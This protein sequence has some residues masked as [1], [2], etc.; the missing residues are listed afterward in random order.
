MKIDHPDQYSLFEEDYLIRELPKGIT[1]KPDVALTELVANA[2]DAGATRVDIHLPE[3]TDGNL[4]VEDDGTGMSYDQFHSRWMKLRYNRIKHQGDQVEFPPELTGLQRAAYGRNGIGRHG[5]LCFN[6]YYEVETGNG[7]EGW[8]YRIV[9]NHPELPF[10]VEQEEKLSSQRRGTKL[11]VRV[12]RHLPNASRIRE[13]ISTRFVH[14]P[15]FAIY[16]NGTVVNL[17]DHSGFLEENTLLTEQGTVLAVLFFDSTKAARHTRQQG[18]AFWVSGRL[19]GE[20]SWI[21]GGH[22]PID[23]RS[24]FAKRYT[25]IVKCDALGQGGQIKE[26]WTGFNDSEVIDAVY[27]TVGKHVEEK[28]RECAVNTVKKTSDEVMLSRRPAIEKLRPSGRME[29]Q[30]FVACITVNDPAIKKEALSIALDAMIEIEQKRDGVELL[31][32]LST[33]SS[34]DISALNKMLDDWSVRDAV[35]VLDEIDK[36][37]KVIEA[38]SKLA[39]D[40]DVDELHTLHPLITQA[41]WV[42]GAEYD[43]KEYASN[44]SLKKAASKVLGVGLESESFINPRKRPDLVCTGDSTFSVA[45]LEECE[46]DTGLLEFKKI[47]I[48][49]L[50]RGGFKISRKEMG[51]ANDYVEDFLASGHLDGC[52]TIDAFVVGSEIAD[53]TQRQRKVGSEDRGKIVAVTFGQLVRT[54]QQ[55]LFRLRDVLNERYELQTGMEIFNNLKV[56]DEQTMEFTL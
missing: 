18:V 27:E 23:G 29:V 44:M 42:F 49:E 10:S 41:R 35:V 50:K 46:G 34:D 30:D 52:F 39:D 33:Y 12:N 26:D 16:V 28:Y 54:A 15:Q 19:V 51:Q 25:F 13:I 32:K 5:L 8:K 36:R 22:S 38:I 43:T 31:Q 45:G 11:S 37:I 2:W 24:H 47:L 21:L 4:S 9:T 20:P 40:P 17:E 7:D 3:S 56:G 6:D 55:R 48:I 53:K 1:G 14:D